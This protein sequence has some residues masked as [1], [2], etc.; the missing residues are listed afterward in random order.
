M[1]NGGRDA[2]LKKL[3]DV[4]MKA[5]IFSQTDSSCVVGSRGGGAVA[6]ALVAQYS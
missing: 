1:R 5:M 3:W 2:K 6:A 4:E